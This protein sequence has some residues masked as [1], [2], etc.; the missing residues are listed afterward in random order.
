MT[1]ER[2]LSLGPFLA[3]AEAE[4]AEPRQ[5]R[6]RERRVREVGQR[7][8]AGERHGLAQQLARRARVTARERLAAP[9]DESLAAHEVDRLGLDVDTYP[10][11]S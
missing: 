7:G 5:R 3:R 2:Q 6:G 4:L 9:L 1:A 10:G 11:A 8:A